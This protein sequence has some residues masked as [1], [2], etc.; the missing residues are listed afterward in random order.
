MC[1]LI[2]VS[3][4]TNFPYAW[5]ADVHE[6]NP[7]GTGIMYVKDGQLF[8]KKALTRT[9]ADAYAFWLENKPEGVE[10]AM[11]F[12]MKTHGA[13]DVDRVHPYRISDDL[14]I[15]HNGILGDD[16]AGRDVDPRKSDTQCF[17]EQLGAQLGELVYN[18]AVAR[19]LGESIG[20][21]NRF[22]FAHPQHGMTIV[23]EDTGVTTEQFP[24]CWFSNTY[25]WTP[26]KWGVK[27]RYA[28]RRMNTYYPSVPVGSFM[29][30]EDDIDW[31]DAWT[32]AYA[33]AIDEVTEVKGSYVGNDDSA[34]GEADEAAS[35]CSEIVMLAQHDAAKFGDASA[36]RFLQVWSSGA[37]LHEHIRLLYPSPEDAVADLLPIKQ[38][39]E[40]SQASF[41]DIASWITLEGK[42]VDN[43]DSGE[44]SP[45]EHYAG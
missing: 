13:I 19:L 42:K 32:R 37:E 38:Y 15:M 40:A 14:L 26:S 28:G 2:K 16:I 6:S 8:H 35:L 11:H 31:Q 9:V 33:P 39:I 10:Y 30:G 5:F 23:N 4:N 45:S 36:K 24:G 22:I 17:A 18:P 41:D 20:Q 21:S 44:P 12:R 29:G 25:A 7:D 3:P 43:V 34:D 1:L 27:S